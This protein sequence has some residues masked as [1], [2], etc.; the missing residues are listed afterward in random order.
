MRKVTLMAVTTLF[1]VGAAQ[2]AV[3]NWGA[4]VQMY[5]AANE[6]GFVKTT[7]D[8][9]LGINGS[10]SGTGST[11]LNGVTFDNVDAAG[12]SN[13]VSGVSGVGLSALRISTGGVLSGYGSYGTG[14]FTDADA[15]SLVSSGLYQASAWTLTGLDVGQEYMMQVMSSDARSNKTSNYG[16]GFSTNGVGSIEMTYRDLP[17]GEWSGG[18]VTGTFIA[19]SDTQAFEVYGTRNDWVSNVE[20]TAQ[21][22]ALQLRAV[23]EPATLGLLGVFGGGLLFMRRRFKR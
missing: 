8:F 11:T 13:G 10:A 1:A 19:D 6:T 2:A 12:I 9:V 23:P 16:S 17:S 3:I 18:Y 22:N 7:G 4:S 15:Q 14:S 20:G 5:D 21:V